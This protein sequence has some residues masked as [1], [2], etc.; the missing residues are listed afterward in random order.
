MSDKK[1]APKEAVTANS[2][3]EP[4]PAYV[5][6][7]CNQK[8]VEDQNLPIETAYRVNKSSEYWKPKSKAGKDALDRYG[9]AKEAGISEVQDDDCGCN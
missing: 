8:S 5:L 9:I 4:L 7:T 1:K 3:P 6:M 2:T